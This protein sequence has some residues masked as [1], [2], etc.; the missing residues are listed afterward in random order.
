MLYNVSQILMEPIGSTRLFDLDEPAPFVEEG[1]AKGRVT[2]GV[3]LLRTHHGLVVNAALDV[4]AYVACARCLTDFV[5]ASALILEEECYST[6]EPNTGRWLSPP[7][8]SERVVHIDS[9]Q[10][11]D[12]S[13]VLRQYLITEEPLKTLCRS[14]CRG[15]CPECGVNLNGEEC[16]CAGQS[17]D[18]RWGAL[19]DL[20]S[21]DD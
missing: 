18:P 16:N 11:L 17:V 8:E 10:M 7:D 1:Q 6:I 4:Q 19:A 14:D 3:R 5:R 20:L 21:K 9:R 12:L 13:D 15:L 2:G